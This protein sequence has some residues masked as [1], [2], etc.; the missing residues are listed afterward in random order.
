LTKKT[1][2]QES[3]SKPAPTKCQV[4]R[5]LKPGTYSQEFDELVNQWF[6]WHYYPLNTPHNA[7]I[8][9]TQEEAQKYIDEQKLS[10]PNFEYEII[11]LDK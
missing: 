4:R 8:F 9:T 3:A 2:S 6:D 5:R 7:D 11:V 1:D 10:W